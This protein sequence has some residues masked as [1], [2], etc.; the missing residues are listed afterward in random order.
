MKLNKNWTTSVESF[1]SYPS[2]CFVPVVLSLST[3]HSK[4]FS[5]ALVWSMWR[6]FSYPLAHYHSTG[7]DRGGGREVIDCVTSPQARGCEG[8]LC[9]PALSGG[10]DW[11]AL[12]HEKRQA[13]KQLHGAGGRE[14]G[15]EGGMD[16]QR[17]ANLTLSCPGSSEP[18]SHPLTLSY[19]SRLYTYMSRKQRNIV[20]CIPNMYSNW[21]YQMFNIFSITQYGTISKK[22]Q[23]DTDNGTE[24]HAVFHSARN[25]ITFL[26]HCSCLKYCSLALATV[27]TA[28]YG[29]QPT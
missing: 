15:K 20:I 25:W 3:L 24:R 23:G 8:S 19:L 11:Q 18:L 27:E 7:G 4:N 22:R 16:T 13:V 10:L 21:L 12:Q 9:N 26:D 5:A 6:R 29:L 14:G 2:S 17:A 1:Y 28:L